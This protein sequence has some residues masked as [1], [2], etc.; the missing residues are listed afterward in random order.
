MSPEYALL[1]NIKLSFQPHTTPT[2]PHT[3][4][5]HPTSHS[6]H[7]PPHSQWTVDTT[8]GLRGQSAALPVTPVPDNVIASVYLRSTEVKSAAT[9]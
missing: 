6:P 9:I 3:L 4:P 8:I 2:Y 1:V 5:P 7:P